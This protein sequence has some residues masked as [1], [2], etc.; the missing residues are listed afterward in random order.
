[1][2]QTVD[3]ARTGGLGQAGQF[4]EGVA[5]VGVGIGQ[6]NADEDGAFLF[7]G[8]LRSLQIGQVLL[9]LLSPAVAGRT[10]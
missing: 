3:H 1:M 5:R 9:S 4:A 2:D 10:H 6:K 8:Q 7:H